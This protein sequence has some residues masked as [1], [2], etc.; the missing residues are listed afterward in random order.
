MIIF[1]KNLLY[2]ICQLFMIFKFKQ[3]YFLIHLE[4]SQNTVHKN[5][6][7]LNCIF[8][9]FAQLNHILFNICPKNY[10]FGTHSFLYNLSQKLLFHYEK[11]IIIYSIYNIYFSTVIQRSL[12]QE[13]VYWLSF[14]VRLL[15]ER[16]RKAFRF[17][18]FFLCLD[19]TVS[20]DWLN[21]CKIENEKQYKKREVENTFFL[22][23]CCSISL[24]S[25][26]LAVCLVVLS[27]KRIIQF[28]HILTIIFW[29]CFLLIGEFKALMAFC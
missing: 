25:E 2:H 27:Y 11:Y 10:I 21:N 14:L 29:S 9:N 22:L 7:R 19:A 8:F 17:F 28:T 20:R 26:V 4:I 23:L 3:H 13:Q 12:Q 1:Q 15:P 24:Y 18:G 6:D 5:F 16:A